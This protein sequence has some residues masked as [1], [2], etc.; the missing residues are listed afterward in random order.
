MCVY[1]DF[2]KNIYLQS[3]K[4]FRK[5]YYEK[6]IFTACLKHLIFCC[7]IKHLLE[8]NASN[9]KSYCSQVSSQ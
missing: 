8:F 9:K 5:N 7:T 6:N 4:L 2:F 1:V 3:Q